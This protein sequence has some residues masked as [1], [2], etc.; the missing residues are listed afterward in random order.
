MPPII[1]DK[2]GLEVVPNTRKL[3]LPYVL[4]LLALSTLVHL[5]IAL[6]GNEINLS[7]QL[8]TGSMAVFFGGFLIIRWEA[9]GQ[10]RF[11]RLVCTRRSSSLQG[12]TYSEAV[13]ISRMT[14][15]GSA[16]RLPWQG[17]G[18]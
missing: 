17:S 4:G 14:T 18:P 3:L 11:G 8:L 1:A 9:L 7:A 5:A 15:A 6:G 12:P 10:V 13:T 16:Q 2:P